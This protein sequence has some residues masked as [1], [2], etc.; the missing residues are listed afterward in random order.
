MKLSERVR[1]GSEA[2]PWVIEEIERLEAEL[3]TEQALSFRNQVAQLEAERDAAV[4]RYEYVRRLNVQ[5]FKALWDR[6]LA[7]YRLDVM[8]D[9]AIDAAKGQK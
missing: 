8:V 3:K 9:A 4:G 6:N 7:G 5:Q 1:A 2:A